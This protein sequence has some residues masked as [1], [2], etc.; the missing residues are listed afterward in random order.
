MPLQ[1]SSLFA[2]L[3]RQL[4]G[5]PA[6]R[7]GNRQAG[8]SREEHA[9]PNQGPNRPFAA[10][11]PASPDHDSENHGNDAVEDEPSGAGERTHAEPH[12][13][14]QDTPHEKISCK[15]KG[16]R[17]QA[18]HGVDEQVDADTQVENPDE[19]LPEE[20][21]RFCRGC[22]ELWILNRSLLK[23]PRSQNRDL[24]HAARWSYCGGVRMN[25]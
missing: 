9:E 17:R 22:G 1:N 20:A 10:G 14:R 11:G 23:N 5:E 6:R 7:Q 24:G 3:L 13:D 15:K 2:K 19:Q 18:R 12:D 8:N 21:A 16:E 4:G 25:W